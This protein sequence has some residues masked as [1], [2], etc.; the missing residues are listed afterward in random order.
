MN[1]EHIISCKYSK[2]KNLDQNLT[3]KQQ[4]EKFNRSFNDDLKDKMNKTITINETNKYLE[5]I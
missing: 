1:L 5:E 2:Y 3:I 4:L